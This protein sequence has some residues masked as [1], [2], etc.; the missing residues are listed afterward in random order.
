MNVERLIR[1]LSIRSDNPLGKGGCIFY[2]IA[3]DQNGVAQGDERFVVVAPFNLLAAVEVEVGQWWH[4][5]GISSTY[6]SLRNGYQI[7]EQQIA[8]MEMRL[9]LPSGQQIVTLLANGKHF[10]G[11]GISKAN[12]LWQRFGESL[13]SVFENGQID[14]LSS[15]QGIS[16]ETANQLVE[17]WK[18]YGQSSLLHLLRTSG[19]DHS[20]VQTVLDHFGNRASDALS[21]DPYRLLS[22]S[23]PWK[24]V[25][26]IALTHFNLR[27][28]DPRRTNGAVEETLYRLF[29]EGHSAPSKP[30]V[31]R[32]LNLI[33]S[34]S[35][36][37][38]H[39]FSSTTLSRLLERAIEHGVCLP[40]GGGERVQQVGA[41]AMEKKVAGFFA[42]R[43]PASR[44]G[45]HEH[46]TL[47]R[48]DY[49]DTHHAQDQPRSSV[50]LTDEQH[51]A[52]RTVARE[53]IGLIS[54]GA[55]VG[56]TTVLR[57][58]YQHFDS[59]GLT[60]IQ[61]AIAGRAAQ[62]MKEATGRPARTLASFLYSSSQDELDEP[63]VLVIDEASMVDIIT[64][65]RLCHALPEHANLLMVGDTSQL[66][67][68]G[69][70]LVFHDLTQDNRIPHARLTQVMRHCSDIA[71]ASA[72]IRAG[73]WPLMG[74]T[75]ESPAAF[76]KPDAIESQATTLHQTADHVLRLYLRYPESTQI[77]C[78][79]KNGL[80][81]VKALNS[82][83]QNAIGLDQPRLRVWN[84]EFQMLAETGFRLDDPIVCTKNL[85]DPG[86][87]NGSLGRIKDL[88]P[89][90]SAPLDNEQLSNDTVLAW[91]EWD[92]GER[93]PITKD[94]LPHLELAYA[95]T[96]HKAQGSEW[97]VVIAPIVHSRLL[98]RSLIYT[99]VTRAQRQ[100]LLLGDEA[101]ARVAVASSTRAS[102][103]ST[104]LLH[105]LTE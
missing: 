16:E 82:L 77:L 21:E 45:E 35:Q 27:S 4:V 13:Q 67:P 33:L 44:V 100:V 103:R 29:S 17:G 79:H 105:H 37:N 72:A 24:S 63:F 88:E 61:V 12:R 2:G 78:A 15:V 73:E 20:T 91:A 81:G 60:V 56:K 26:T 75:E 48:Q 42:N 92:D 76:L 38:P 25:D 31:L 1:V 39:V 85:K 30:T 59:I 104:G 62:R 101:A 58:L 64:M 99:A 18:L 41:W 8:P 11:V 94:L 6:S 89:P 98:D 86:L 23:A 49:D 19:I 32:R 43:L 51:S 9:L 22:F 84:D 96:I 10:A 68:V 71:L 102:R 69:P 28:D 52:I 5:S 93:R 80:L 57:A 47:S 36:T 34:S 7:R 66:M 70:G 40:I 95:L 55:G 74:K 83:C 50:Q 54:G 14:L 53:R 65:Y 87:Q 97:P 46:A 90:N 3:I